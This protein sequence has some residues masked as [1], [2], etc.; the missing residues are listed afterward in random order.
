M[1]SGRSRIVQFPRDNGLV[2]L[3]GHIAAYPV[4]NTNQQQK[5]L[6]PQAK[7]LNNATNLL[8]AKPMQTPPLSFQT[9]QAIPQQKHPIKVYPKPYPV[10]QPYPVPVRVPVPKPV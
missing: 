2:A 3:G 10:P 8:N 4:M 6:V 9:P 7:P 1:G 5:Q